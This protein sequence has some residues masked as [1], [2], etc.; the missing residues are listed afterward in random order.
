MDTGFKE[1]VSV[2][3]SWDV[4]FVRMKLIWGRLSNH[5][6]VAGWEY[7]RAL[8]FAK[9]ISSEVWLNSN[10]QRRNFVWFT[11][12]NRVPIHPGKSWDCVYKIF[13]TWKVLENEFG[14]GKSGKSKCKVLEFGRQWYGW[15]MQ[16]RGCWHQKMRIH[17][18][19]F[20]AQTVSLLFLDNMWQWWLINIYSSMDAAIILYI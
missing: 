14:L 13:T 2:N 12:K 17:T 16:W 20:C 15:R 6:G 18:P 4:L 1:F 3:L 10:T 9:P 11:D 8:T 7:C 5:G 19:L